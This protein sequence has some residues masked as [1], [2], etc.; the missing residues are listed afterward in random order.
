[1]AQPQP[2]HHRFRW[3]SS[4]LRHAKPSVAASAKRAASTRHRLASCTG[5]S[6]SDSMCPRSRR[7]RASR[8]ANYH[9]A[10][11]SPR[12]AR[13]LAEKHN[14]GARASRHYS[15][16]RPRPAPARRRRAAAARA[17]RCQRPAT[18]SCRLLSR[19]P[20]ASR[21]PAPGELSH[22]TAPPTRP[23]VVA[24]SVRFPGG[25]YCS[26]QF[27]SFACCFSRGLVGCKARL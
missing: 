2:T 11:A 20:A 14:A 24:G 15:C 3:A 12:C 17:A 26:L 9:H 27:C 7:R 23:G 4:S 8:P 10:A 18:A 5:S 1:M 25:P 13:G 19:T 22:R 21:R 16:A 6:V